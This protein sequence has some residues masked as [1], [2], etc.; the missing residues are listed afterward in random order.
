VVVAK[1]EGGEIRKKIIRRLCTGNYFHRPRGNS[2][3]KRLISGGSPERGRVEVQGNRGAGKKKKRLRT[4][5]NLWKGV[6]A[7]RLG[8]Y[9]LGIGT[10]GQE[11]ICLGTLEN[12]KGC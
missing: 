10:I 3:G 2:L 9:P 5:K 11:G 8:I 1:K 7:L 6:R 12:C 4:L